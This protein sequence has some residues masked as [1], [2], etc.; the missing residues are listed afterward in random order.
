[1]ADPNQAGPIDQSPV[2]ENQDKIVDVYFGVFFDA[3]DMSV[4]A[5][6]FNRGEYMRKGEEAVSNVKNSSTYKTV[7]EV[8]AW[9]KF[10]TDVLPDNPVSKAVNTALG[11]KDTIENKVDDYMGKV[12]GISD[13]IAGLGDKVPTSFGSSTE[14]GEKE[15]SG[16]EGL[17]GSRSIIS[18]LES[19]YVGDYFGTNYNFR[20]YTTGA[21]TN[22]ELKQKNE[23]TP[24]LDE[25]TRSQ[26]EKDGIDAAI[27][28]IKQQINTC[29]QSKL[30]LH[31]DIFGYTKDPAVNKFISE[32]DQF[33]Q[34]PNINELSI[35]FKGLYDNFYSKEEVM[36]SMNEDTFIR[37]RNLNKL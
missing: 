34:I 22:V 26:F 3:I 11:V 16:N 9:A 32:I 18:K 19:G 7:D 29:P 36:N 14:S 5:Q 17:I 13:D 35:D 6:Y 21:V 33:K 27:N 8:A 23:E 1:M 20:I 24:Q 30:S 25:N 15:E 28:A 12:E 2:S 31:F 4:M 37:F 10:A